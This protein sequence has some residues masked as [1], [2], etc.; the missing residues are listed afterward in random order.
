MAP[1]HLASLFYSAQNYD[2]LFVLTFL[3]FYTLPLDVQYI[4][5]TLLYSMHVREYK[6]CPTRKYYVTGFPPWVNALCNRHMEDLQ[7]ES[8]NFSA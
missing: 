3:L 5:S 2:V 4:C 6:L 1:T 8:I 7:N